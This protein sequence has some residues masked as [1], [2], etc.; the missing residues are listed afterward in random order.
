MPA[1]ERRIQISDDAAEVLE[2]RGIRTEDVEMVIQNAEKNGEKLYRPN[3]ER[4]LAK[5]VI[6]EAT[7]YVEYSTTEDTYVVHTAYS[8]RTKLGE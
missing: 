1:Q 6:E 5:L 3:E 2:I 8:H 7:F 4:C